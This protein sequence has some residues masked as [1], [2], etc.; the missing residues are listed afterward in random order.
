[1]GLALAPTFATGLAWLAEK[2]PQRAEQVSPAV[3][4]AAAVGPI[5][6]APLVGVALSRFGPAAV[7]TTLAALAGLAFLSAVWLRRRR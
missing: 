2:L 6:T 1:M 4:A 3:F 7:P 5:A